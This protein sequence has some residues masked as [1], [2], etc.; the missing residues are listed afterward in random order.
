MDLKPALMHAF[1]IADE[2]CQIV[3]DGSVGVC[4][5]DIALHFIALTR[6][7]FSPLGTPG[8]HRWR[9]YM[10]PRVRFSHL[11]RC[12]VNSLRL[13][14]IPWYFHSRAASIGVAEYCI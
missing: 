3:G 6:V 13:T 11:A 14:S 2:A 12:V 7:P 1:S 10:V 4:S 9:L 8:G 5:Q